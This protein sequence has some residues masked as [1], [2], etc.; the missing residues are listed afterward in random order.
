[1]RMWIDIMRDMEHLMHDYARIF[2]GWQ[3]GGVTGMVIG[4]LVFDSPDLVKVERSPEAPGG[5]AAV[6]KARARLRLRRCGH[7]G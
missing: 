6:A 3:A 2:D 1:M 4:P 7:F 5:H